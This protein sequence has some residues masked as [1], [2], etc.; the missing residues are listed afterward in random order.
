MRNLDAITV[1]QIFEIQRTRLLSAGPDAL[2]ELEILSANESVGAE[3]ISF[4]F[5]LTQLPQAIAKISDKRLT[6]NYCRLVIKLLGEG[7]ASA[8]QLSALTEFFQGVIS[9]KLEFLTEAPES[10]FELFYS[11]GKKDS[12]FNEIKAALK[13]I[14]SR[15][16][17]LLGSELINRC[18]SAVAGKLGADGNRIIEKLLVDI[19]NEWITT[20]ASVTRINTTAQTLSV[21]IR[22]A[23]VPPLEGSLLKPEA[24]A[25]LIDF[26]GYTPMSGLE[27]SEKRLLCVR[28]GLSSDGI[29]SREI[30]QL[31]S[32]KLKAGDRALLEEILDPDSYLMKSIHSRS[33]RMATNHFSD[34][35]KFILVV[36]DS[37]LSTGNRV[38]SLGLL[39]FL[40]TYVPSTPS[41]NMGHVFV[42]CSI[43]ADRLRFFEVLMKIAEAHPV[44]V[45]S[46]LYLR[47]LERARG[48]NFGLL[49]LNNYPRNDLDYGI[50][51]DE[52]AAEKYIDLLEFISIQLGKEAVVEFVR[53]QSD[54][55]GLKLSQILSKRSD[56]V[57]RFMCN[58][59]VSLEALGKLKGVKHAMAN[60]LI[61][62]S[63]TLEKAGA[64][65]LLREALTRESYL[66]SYFYLQRASRPCAL[67]QHGA[68]DT[69]F[70]ELQRRDPDAAARFRPAAT[71]SS[72]VVGLFGRPRAGS[73]DEVRAAVIPHDESGF[74]LA[75][76]LSDGRA[77]GIN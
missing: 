34:F 69:I 53:G 46:Y 7:N 58:N 10:L 24:K 17:A 30:F 38:D 59:F 54:N 75:A 67:G 44:P 68:L 39:N 20:K 12:F 70:A 4:L 16:Q 18:R 6:E 19:A 35:A 9:R 61:K 52:K 41:A 31:V 50:C 36:S 76:F 51:A 40:R 55:F 23:L 22:K 62:H 2:E 45:L 73:R 63:R 64:V 29:T 66:G 32:E 8:E 25:I 74:E 71:A 5:E 48:P 26:R 3:V 15:Q 21:L 57:F 47:P 37:A 11:A 33:G 1:R 43:N 28:H 42:Q 14:L 56:L 77:A 60:E 49:T 27:L 65:A 72:S 13:K